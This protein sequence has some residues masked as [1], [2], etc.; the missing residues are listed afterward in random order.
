M[1]MGL[2][3]REGRLMRRP[4]LSIESLESRRVFA[5]FSLRVVD[6]LDL[7]SHVVEGQITH[8]ANFAM[9]RISQHIAWQGVLD[10]EV[11]IRPASEN[12]YSNANGIMPSIISVSWFNDHW[13]NDTLYEM[14]TGIDRQPQNADV[15]MTIYLG[16]DGQIRN[17]G[18]PVWFDPNPFDYV[19]ADVP[20]GMC[21][22]I[23]VFYH[24]IFHGMGM[25]GVSR[26]F[27]NLTTTIDGNDYFIGN[28]TQ[29]VFGGPLPLAPRTGGSLQ[30]HYG[31]TSLPTN[32]LSSGLMFQWGNY[33]GNR[34]DIGKLDLAILEDLGIAITNQSGLPLVDT[35]DSQI[36]RNTLSHLSIS[37]NVAIGTE[38]GKLSTT[39]GSLGLFLRWLMAGKT[40]A[41]SNS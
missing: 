31:N 18:L 32:T 24:E 22:Y 8:S 33:E 23:G 36:P 1:K 11:R 34:L 25:L 30:D 12:P 16:N 37:E 38:V 27:Q 2:E 39:D 3:T 9:N 19:P 26:E 40:T 17:Y 4:R 28:Q 21:D 13:S 14:L 20:T 6:D 41:F 15:G 29:H 5:G 10:A 35:I 7:V